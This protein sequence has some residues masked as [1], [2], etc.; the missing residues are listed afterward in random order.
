MLTLLFYMA[1]LVAF[2][3]L[4]ARLRGNG[5]CLGWI[6]GTVCLIGFLVLVSAHH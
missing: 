3:L 1:A 2:F 4:L 6:V 5:R